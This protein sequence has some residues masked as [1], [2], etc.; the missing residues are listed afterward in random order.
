MGGFL[1]KDFFFLGGGGGVPLPHYV[2]DFPSLID[3]LRD[4]KHL[5]I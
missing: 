3:L 1:L 2:G 5:V 4:A